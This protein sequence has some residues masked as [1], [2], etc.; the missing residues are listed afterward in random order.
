MF[1]KISSELTH[2]NCREF[3]P[4]TSLGLVLTNCLKSQIVV[5]SLLVKSY[6]LFRNELK[7]LNS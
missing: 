1:D 4:D 2:W 5:E 7:G 6:C 3:I